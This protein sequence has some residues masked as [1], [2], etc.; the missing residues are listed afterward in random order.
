M[1]RWSLFLSI[2]ISVSFVFAVSCVSKEVPVTETYSETEYKTE[3][4]TETYTDIEDVVVGTSEGRTYPSPVIRWQAGLYFAGGDSG[5][6]MKYYGYEID[7]SEHTRNEVK[8]TLSQIAE[9]YLMVIDL[10]G[11]GQISSMPVT[12]S[13]WREENPQTGD[14]WLNPAEQAW[15]D[16]LEAITTNPERVLVYQPMNTDTGSEISFDATG[17]QTFAMLSNSWNEKAIQSVKLIW[18]DNITEKRTMTKERQVPY[19]VP[20]QVEKQRTVMRT[21]LVPFWEAIFH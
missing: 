15:I 20:V 4:K 1:G 5:T 8:I 2:I 14:L 6:G 17:I 9:G 12:I 11:L 13:A 7:T 10:T 21:K 16:K 3:Y 19:E 18:S